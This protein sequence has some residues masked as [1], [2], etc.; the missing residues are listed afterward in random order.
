MSWLI[1]DVHT[2]L[3]FSVRHMMVT[4]VRGQFK[5]YRGTVD[6]DP[7]DFARSTFEGEVDVASIE[8][9]NAQRDDHLRT[10]DFFDAPNH[11]KIRF[12]STRIE[13]KGDN[14]YVVHGDIT[15]RGVTKPVS[16]DVEFLGTSKN[17]WGKTVAGLSARATVNRKE[18]G[19]NYNAV[20]EAGGVAVGEKV[21]IE[22]DAELVAPEAVAKTG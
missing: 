10:N 19:V 13:S 14:Q 7:A 3:G 20:L 22:I 8:T 5:Q 18:F 11:P 15:I 2:H 21:K 4:T 9:G 6:I 16:F 12:K 1:D 17:P